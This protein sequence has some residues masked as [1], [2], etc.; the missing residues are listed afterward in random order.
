[1]LVVKHLKEE[2][3]DEP[4]RRLDLSTDQP[5]VKPEASAHSKDHVPSL[6][7]R[8]GSAPSL[9]KSCFKP[10]RHI[11]T[12]P[13]SAPR[14]DVGTRHTTTPSS[15]SLNASESARRNSTPENSP[16]QLINLRERAEADG[17]SN[18]RPMAHRSLSKIEISNVDLLWGRLFDQNF[19]PTR[20]LS[21]LL[22]G[23]A[24]YITK[25]FHPKRGFL[26][27]PEKMAA[28]YQYYPMEDEVYPLFSIFKS[29]S[30]NTLSELFQKLNCEHFLAQ[31]DPSMQPTIPALSPTGFE[32]WMTV[33]I[34]AYPDQEARR[35]KKVV[36]T[37]P[38]DADNEVSDGKAE[39]I[40]TE[41]SRSLFP[42]KENSEFRN[43]LNEAMSNVTESFDISRWR[44][45][46]KPVPQ[47]SQMPQLKA[48]GT[49][50]SLKS[51]SFTSQHSSIEIQSRKEFVSHAFTRAISPDEVNPPSEILI[52]KSLPIDASEE[53][54]KSV[55]S[56]LP[57]YIRLG[58]YT[59]SSSCFVHFEDI[60]DAEN[61]LRDLRGSF[62]VNHIKYSDAC[63]SFADNIL[64]P[65]SAH[66]RGSSK[67]L[68]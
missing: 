20:R 3:N 67:N 48:Q 68:I 7:A 39:R 47:T 58:F 14:L 38:I 31:E 43:I 46:S 41:I 27:T 8:P 19:N 34:L 25:E 49:V 37:L 6:L 45:L 35:L 42:N 16:A 11:P 53:D 55:F 32:R 57:G 40:P 5:I 44:K 30:H 1:V 59:G 63:I 60:S 52:V 10:S 15:R 54:L 65:R 50:S 12:P 26:V 64:S 17:G 36:A 62:P 33:W 4:D 9:P 23:L 56:E 24:N 28:F 13:R 29:Q 2:R 18:L 51:P 66:R 21:Q 22:R 61:A